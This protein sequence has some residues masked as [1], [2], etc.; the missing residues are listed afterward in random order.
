MNKRERLE[1]IKRFRK[2]FDGQVAVKTVDWLITELEAAWEQNRVMR[3]AL[4]R[5]GGEL[6]DISGHDEMGS[7]AQYLLSVLHGETRPMRDFARTALEKV[8]DDE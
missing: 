8:K 4:E 2:P 1:K 6:E 3:E 7:T 5:I